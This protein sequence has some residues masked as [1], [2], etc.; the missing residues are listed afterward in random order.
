M[1]SRSLPE[2]KGIWISKTP[3][4]SL[5]EQYYHVFFDGEGLSS[6]DKDSDYDIKLLLLSMMISSTFIYNSFGAIEQSSL[7]VL[8]SSIGLK[9]HCTEWNKFPFTDLIW[10]AR[11]FNLGLV[12]REGNKIS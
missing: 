6:I 5:D 2:T 9:K 8:R 12:D 4:L 3:I 10:L 7:E 1:S 11:D